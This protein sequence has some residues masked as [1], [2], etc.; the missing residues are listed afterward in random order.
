[1]TLALVLLGLRILSA[2]LLLALVGVLFLVL[3]SDFSNATA[4]VEASRRVY[5]YLIGLKDMNGTYT[6]SGEMYPL[7]P[8]TTLGRAPTNTI[9]LDDQF[10]SSEHAMVILRSGVWWLEDINSSNG[11]NLNGLTINQ[12]VIVTNGDIINIGTH[13]FRLELDAT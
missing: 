9:R 13:H 1:M 11:T 7:L 10:A 6:P 5:G 12:P 4:E 8:T 3:W 2:L